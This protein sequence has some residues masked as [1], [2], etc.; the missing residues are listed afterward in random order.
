M[1]QAVVFI[2]SVGIAYL[3]SVCGYILLRKGISIQCK[4][5]VIGI[6]CLNAF[7]GIRYCQGI[8]PAMDTADIFVVV[9]PTNTQQINHIFIQILQQGLASLVHRLLYLRIHLILNLVESSIDFL[10][11]T[12]GLIDFQQAF[13]K[14]YT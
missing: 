12:T 13:L 9:L 1:R 14:I 8:E 4:N 2:A 3:I 10:W 11:C 7:R 6:C 5:E